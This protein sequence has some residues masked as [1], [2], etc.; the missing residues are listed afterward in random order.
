MTQTEHETLEQIASALVNAFNV[1]APPVPVETMLQ[2]PEPGMWQ[3]LNVSQLSGSFLSF[4]EPFSPR[5]SMVRL[6]VRHLIASPWGGNYNLPAIIGRDEDKLR[7]LARMIIMP[8]EMIE[9]IP[10][11]QRSAAYIS[12]YFEVPE[13]DAQARLLDLS[14]E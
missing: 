5:M 4:K 1:H 9:A 14:L 3:E 11:M 13:S 2:K 8:R 12:S 10:V 6:L 7:L